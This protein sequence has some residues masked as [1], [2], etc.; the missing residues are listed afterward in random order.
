MVNFGCCLSGC[1]GY[2][3]CCDVNFVYSDDRSYCILGMMYIIYVYLLFFVLFFLFCIFG[4]ICNV[5]VLFIGFIVCINFNVEICK[6]CMKLK[7]KGVYL[8]VFE[9]IFFYFKSCDLGIIYL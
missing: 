5:K 4:L 8:R 6:K 2:I 9:N 3:C 1:D 7:F